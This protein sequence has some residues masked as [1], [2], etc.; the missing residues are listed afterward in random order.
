MLLKS[1]LLVLA[2]LFCFAS[3]VSAIHFKGNI[4]VTA[5]ANG[6]DYRKSSIYVIPFPPIISYTSF[7]IERSNQGHG[8][9]QF[10]VSGIYGGGFF[11]YG[12]FPFAYLSSFAVDGQINKGNKINSS[13]FSASLGYIATAYLRIE[14][15][16]P[17]G[18]VVASSSLRNSQIVDFNARIKWATDYTSDD[19]TLSQASIV[20]TPQDGSGWI[21][22]ITF[23]ASAVVGVIDL[24]GAVVGPSSL[25]QVVQINN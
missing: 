24:A 16:S 21:I 8:N 10:N 9:K 25:E 4:S 20:G 12:Q 18:T 13:D 19:G 5:S 11:N 14:E 17:N 22:N 2:T 15:K 6:W 3:H 23:V 1:V 7:D